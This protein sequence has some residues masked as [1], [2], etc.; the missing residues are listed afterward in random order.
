LSRPD[1]HDE[2]YSES[3]VYVASFHLL[4]GKLAA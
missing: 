2:A 3:M 1:E 4:L